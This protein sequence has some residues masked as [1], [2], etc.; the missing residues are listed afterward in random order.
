MDSGTSN[1]IRQMANF[2]LQEAHEKGNEINI[3]TEHDFNL[4]K[5]M[6]VHN[7]KIKIQEEYMQKEK[8]R[9]IQDRIQRST[10]IGNSRVQKMTAR[11]TLL[12]D[13]LG[14]ATE[15]IT[16]VS[17]GD[18][19]PDLLK[20]LMVQG[21]IKIEEENL[22]VVCRE[23]DIPAAKSVLDMAVEEYT[24]LMKTDAEIDVKMNVTVNEVPSACLPASC[25]GGVVL[26]AVNGRILC[27]NT[28][29]ARLEI[30]YKE[31]L[32][33]IRGL[34]FPVATS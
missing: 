9:E 20:S 2:I 24:A 12:K 27:D 26:S 11:D 29:S 23:A 31:L 34:L 22:T 33:K 1:R 4:E 30:A 7:A 3:K 15:R 32:P 5:Q 25:P 8:E 13:L 21:M 17:N 14:N 18:D 10:M 28:L 6:L 16:T 19:Y